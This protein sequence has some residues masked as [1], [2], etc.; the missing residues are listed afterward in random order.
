[1]GP[2]YTLIIPVALLYDKD[3]QLQ[4]MRIV[5]C[6]VACI[7]ND[8]Y[9]HPET[10][11]KAKGTYFQSQLYTL[12]IADIKQTE[13]IEISMTNFSE[14]KG[15]RTLVYGNDGVKGSIYGVST[16]TSVVDGKAVNPN[17]YHPLLSHIGDRTLCIHGFFDY[18]GAWHAGI[19]D[20]P[21][22]EPF[23]AE[24]ELLRNICVRK[25]SFTLTSIQEQ[26]LSKETMLGD[27]AMIRAGNSP[28]MILSAMSANDTA[29]AAATTLMSSATSEDVY[30][31]YTGRKVYRP[32]VIT[33][34][35]TIPY[36]VQAAL[37]HASVPFDKGK[38]VKC[39]MLSQDLD[40]LKIVLHM[41]PMVRGIAHHTLTSYTLHCANL[42]TFDL[43]KRIC[44]TVYNKDAMIDIS[45][46]TAD[47][48]GQCL[49]I[50]ERTTDLKTL[51]IKIGGQAWDSI[52]SPAPR[53]TLELITKVER[54][55]FKFCL[56]PPVTG[57]KGK[58]KAT[59]QAAI[60]I[61]YDGDMEKPKL[62]VLDLR[63]L[64]E[65]KQ[66]GITT[67]VLLDTGNVKRVDGRK[68]VTKVILG[69]S[70]AKASS[71]AAKPAYFCLS[72][73]RT[74]SEEIYATHIP[75]FSYTLRKPRLKKAVDT[76]IAGQTI[77]HGDIDTLIITIESQV[78]DTPTKDIYIDGTVRN[79]SIC[80]SG[81]QGNHTDNLRRVRVH[82]KDRNS[83]NIVARRSPY[84]GRY[85]RRGAEIPELKACTTDKGDVVMTVGENGV[86][87]LVLE[88][89]NLANEIIVDY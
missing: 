32:K 63:V 5:R 14:H 56:T 45:S 65:W 41:S 47:Y 71:T 67:Q 34:I 35:M 81:Y 7:E 57:N 85:F 60:D 27:I 37:F 50:S 4:K 54:P 58:I 30:S 88:Q 51:D 26:Q 23:I 64:N 29:A 6:K 68:Q 1:M 17:V 38:L 42:S 22:R 10:I 78:E 33:P 52:I 13:V 24:L 2:L 28:T 75:Y 11:A 53:S 48:I 79:I 18:T 62:T 36:G 44:G 59:S 89:G 21:A 72:T 69:N 31:E 55:E 39:I 61:L 20:I 8:C 66:I 73:D 49:N 12:N 83:V 74:V 70:S 82:V 3:W 76:S 43:P 87:V 84:Y 15:L 16:I 80:R 9:S 77:I 86:P 40:E 46:Y 19:T 25:A